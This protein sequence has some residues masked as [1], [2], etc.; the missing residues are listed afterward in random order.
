MRSD[1]E[2]S[3]SFFICA[4]R[5]ASF[6][7]SVSSSES[8]SSLKSPWVSRR[9]IS[10]IS[11][12]IISGESSAVSAFLRL[13]SSAE[14]FSISSFLYCSKVSFALRSVSASSFLVSVIP[15]AAPVISLSPAVISAFTFVSS[16]SVRVTE[17]VGHLLPAVRL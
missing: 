16:S 2:Y 11:F 9:S 4:S 3:R 7:V 10:S 1:A 5:A 12:C 15:F 8:S 6:F 13:S 14:R 17:Q